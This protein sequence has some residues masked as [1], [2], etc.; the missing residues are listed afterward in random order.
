MQDSSQHEH[1]KRDTARGENP[2]FG[3]GPILPSVVSLFS[4]RFAMVANCKARQGNVPASP[5]ADYQ[6]GRRGAQGVSDRV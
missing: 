5:R 2:R 4:A 1:R 3:H 6:A